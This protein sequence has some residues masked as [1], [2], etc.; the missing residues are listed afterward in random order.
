MRKGKLK[1]ERI[2]VIAFCGDGGGAD[3]GLGAIS[4]ALTHADYSFLVILYDNE[5]YAN[6]DIQLSGSDPLGR[7]DDLQPGGQGQADHAQALEEERAGHAGGRPSRVEVHRLGL[8][9]VRH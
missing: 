9:L 4:A 3:M 2:N 7:G 1:D 6:T 5:S 8:R